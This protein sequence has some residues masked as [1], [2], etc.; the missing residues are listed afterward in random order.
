MSRPTASPTAS[1]ATGQT[2]RTVATSGQVSAAKDS[3]LDHPLRLSATRLETISARL[4]EG[5]WR[6]LNFVSK[7]RLASGKQLARGLWNADRQSAPSQARIARRK[8]KRLSDWRVLD[9]LPDRT[10]GGLH[11]GSDTIIYGVGAAGVR[12]LARRGQHQKRLGR[13]GARYVAHTLACTEVVVDLNVLAAQG[14]LEVIETQQEP[15]CWR[16]FLGGMGARIILKPDLYLRVAAPGSIYESRWMVE[17]DMATEA[18]TTIRSKAARYLAHYR[19]GS[20]QRKHGV[21]PR[22]LWAVP[23]ARRAEQVREALDRLPAPAERLFAIC[24]QHEV[25][26]RLIAEARS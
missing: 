23:D 3:P 18:S 22:V 25:S 21:Y 2:S 16:S 7:C 19:A 10:V 14:E 17:L 1:S 9:P 6:V 24:L 13:P 5:D 20:E 4:V 8:I 26:S 12:L 15:Q 11:G